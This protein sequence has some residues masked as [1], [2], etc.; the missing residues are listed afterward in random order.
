MRSSVSRSIKPFCDE[1]LWVSVERALAYFSFKYEWLN[2]LLSFGSDMDL[3]KRVSSEVKISDTVLELGCGP[4]TM[5]KLLN[6]KEYWGIDPLNIMVAI[7]KKRVRKENFHFIKGCA[8]EIPFEN[9]KFDKVI[10][11]F[12]FRDFKHKLESL[13]EIFRVLKKGGKLI[14]LDLANTDLPSSKILKKYYLMLGKFLTMVTGDK[15]YLTLKDLVKTIEDFPH[16]WILKKWAEKIGFRKVEIEYYR[17][18]TVFIL[19]AEKL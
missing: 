1:E 5:A 19:K 10:T 14:I 17:F 18:G 4:G 6:C 11:S 15:I 12:A 7:A 8:E 3:R 9:E 16:P 13:Y 2:R